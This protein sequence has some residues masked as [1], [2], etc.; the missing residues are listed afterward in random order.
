MKHQKYQKGQKVLLLDLQDNPAVNAVIESYN[1][2]LELYKI[3]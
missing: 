1:S 3:H 2:E